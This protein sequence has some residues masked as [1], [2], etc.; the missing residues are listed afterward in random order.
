MTA[1]L[2]IGPQPGRQT[3]FLRSSADI[4]IY[5]G[6]AG[7]G[8]THALLLEPLYHVHVPHFGAVFFRQ[9]Y[10][11]ITNEGGLWDNSLALYNQIKPSPRPVANRL[12]WHF[13]DSVKISFRHMLR[14]QDK[15]Q[16]QGSQMC[17]QLWDQLEQFTEAQFFYMLARNRSTCGVTPY[18]R[19][20]CNPQPG[21]LGEFISW[22]I[23]PAD[24]YPILERAGV[25]R[26]ML[27][28]GG[29]LKWADSPEEL[30]AEY[31]ERSSDGE[32]HDLEPK[33]VTFIP[34][35][36]YDNP[37]LLDK[38]PSYLANLQALGEVDRMR[39]LGD[40]LRGGNWHV[41][42]GGKMF[43]R[44]WFQIRKV[45]PAGCQRNVRF[46]DLAATAPKKSNKDPDFTVG[47]HIGYDQGLWFIMHIARRRDTPMSI[48][49]LVASVAETDGY[50]MPIRMEQEGGASG[51]SII[52]HYR[53]NVLA[54]YAFQGKKP[55]DNKQTRATIVAAEAEAG[56]VYLIEG[57]WNKAF[58]DEA[59]SFPGGLHDDQ[60]DAVSGGFRELAKLSGS[61]FMA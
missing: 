48:E 34:A 40:R 13:S 25:K 7:S 12:E 37:I 16:Y 59:E 51:P 49:K 39:L 9:T 38:D 17:L 52:D 54:G 3:S 42:P 4:A 21:W 33:S 60:I 31:G 27:R 35:T 50:N 15:Y 57:D 36:V 47:A 26:Y 53:R 41:K 6:A 1:R 10:P 44:E 14:E 2:T 32:G 61:G 55:D 56:N 19:A 46:W 29:E 18:V 22:W 23:D 58:L 11:Q 24:G 45:K 20:T 8:K 43:K 5:G 28:I 30:K